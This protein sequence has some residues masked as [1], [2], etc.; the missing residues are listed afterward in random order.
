MAC[1]AVTAGV[2]LP[3]FSRDGGK[4]ILQ[5]LRRSSILAF[6]VF[7]LPLSATLDGSVVR[8]ALDPSAGN[9]PAKAAQLAR[10]D[11]IALS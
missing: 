8:R 1:I 7:S 11:N 4:R 10:H 2:H 6:L 9:I 3:S 5:P